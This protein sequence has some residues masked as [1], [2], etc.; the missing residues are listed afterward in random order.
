ME[1]RTFN[2]LGCSVILDKG[3][4]VISIDATWTGDPAWT[5]DAELFAKPS[6][7]QSRGFVSAGTLLMKAKQFEY[8]LGAAVAVLIQE[9]SDEFFGMKRLLQ[10]LLGSLPR[11]ATD[12]T[13]SVA[14][15]FYAACELGKTYAS[16]PH[17]LQ[18]RVSAVV[19]SFLAEKSKSLPVSF[20]SW[21][22]T[23]SGLYRQ[24]RMLEEPLVWEGQQQ[25]IDA[26]RRM[27]SLKRAY[28]DVVNLAGKMS[29]PSRTPSLLSLITSATEISPSHDLPFFPK[30]TNR[31][32][33]L[34]RKLYGDKQLPQGIV[35][36]EETIRR[37]RE[38]LL[39]FSPQDDSTWYDYLFWF[40]EPLVRVDAD[41]ESSKRSL[42]TEYRECL[43]DLYRDAQRFSRQPTV[44]P[45]ETRGLGAVKPPSINVLPECTV[46][47]LP[48]LYFRLARCYKFLETVLTATFGAEALQDAIRPTAVGRAPVNL[49]QELRQMQSLFY[50]AHVVA[51][52]ELGIEPFSPEFFFERLDAKASA[53]FFRQWMNEISTDC[54][55]ACDCRSMMPVYFD[56]ER[57][58]TRVRVFLGWRRVKLNL[59]Y[60]VPPAIVAVDT[61][62]FV[63]PDH[64]RQMLGGDYK[65]DVKF[66]GTTVEAA[67]PAV[68]EINVGK[69]LP[70]EE[71]AAFCDQHKSEWAIMD[72]LIDACM[73]E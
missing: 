10:G 61:S 2:D 42:S 63:L 47:P 16:I 54:D 59:S 32:A 67:Y 8:G 38:G 52:N 46:E 69:T 66:G 68:A 45:K 31:E 24:E 36:V 13:M 56:R 37:L 25:L 58:L 62:G 71:F 26:L 57:G 18:E 12:A 22:D 21:N 60:A 72:G 48:S 64:Y 55:L 20:Y 19:E 50:G 65:P 11:P 70:A 1:L 29:S 7:A 43:L 34:V 39:S 28:A 5:A 14:A 30:A 51:S 6:A 33:E 17:V 40:A 53:T 73:R 23:L 15:T 44:K 3:P 4:Q 41:P 35:L 27:Q 9:G 49:R